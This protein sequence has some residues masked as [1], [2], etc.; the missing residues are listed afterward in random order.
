MT[1]HDTAEQ[2]VEHASLKPATYRLLVTGCVDP[3]QAS[4]WNHRATDT[5]PRNGSSD[6]AHGSIYLPRFRFGSL[7]RRRTA[8]L[9]AA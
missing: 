1:R 9:L 2:T 3:S 6:A 5:A 4:R 8:P 7:R